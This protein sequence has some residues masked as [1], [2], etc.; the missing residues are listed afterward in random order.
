MT[1]VN[2]CTLPVKHSSPAEEYL[3]NPG[4]K[5]AP[6]CESRGWFKAMRGEAPLELI[7]RSPNAFILASVIAYR[8]RWR[9]GFNADGLALGEAMLGDCDA[10]GMSEQEYRTAKA[11]LKRWRFA[12]FR[13]TNRGTIGKLIDTRLF[14]IL[15]DASN[16]QNNEQVT[17]SQRLTKNRRTKLRPARDSRT[18]TAALQARISDVKA[19]LARE[20]NP[21][22]GERLHTELAALTAQAGA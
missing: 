11:Q 2:P 19:E 17:N 22:K 13:S 15:P 8:A 6:L 1:K 14:S 21:E 20:N 16:D 9:Q 12:T 4:G 5:G 18:D 3:P 7:R 10:M